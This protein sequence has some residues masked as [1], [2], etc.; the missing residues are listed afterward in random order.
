M[1]YRVRITKQTSNRGPLGQG[2]SFT[3]SASRL[4]TVGN[5]FLMVTSGKFFN[6]ST[7]RKIKYVN[8]DLL[9]E[10]LNSQYIVEILST[11][12]A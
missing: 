8:G 2:E 6:T 9:L 5:A 1:A 12:E 3:G 7:V 11:D 4:P 10:T